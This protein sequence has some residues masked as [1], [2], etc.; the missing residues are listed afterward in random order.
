MHSRLSF[1]TQFYNIGLS[2]KI[3]TT[4]HY[5]ISCDLQLQHSTRCYFVSPLWKPNY[6]IQ[7]T[8][9]HYTLNFY[10]FHWWWVRQFRFILFYFI[11]C[12]LNFSLLFLF[13][14]SF[15]LVFFFGEFFV[16][17]KKWQKKFRFRSL[18]FCSPI[19]IYK[20]HKLNLVHVF[21]TCTQM[22][23]IKFLHFF[24]VGVI[25]NMFVVAYFRIEIMIICYYFSLSFPL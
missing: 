2:A 9:Q 22:L 12:V 13:S 25:Q 23:Y 11:L 17:V 19:C 7:R 10:C 15:S 4:I 21:I 16:F 20:T 6:K 14:S 3:E 24:F 1:V 5:L 8:T 18:Y